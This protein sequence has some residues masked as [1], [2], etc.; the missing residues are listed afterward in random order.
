MTDPVR[1]R[2]L[3]ELDQVTLCTRILYQ[4][5][6]ELYV[7]MK[8][9]DVSLSSLGF[10]AD[11]GRD[12]LGTD[13]HLIYYGPDY[14]L[15]LYKRG[16]TLVNRGY[17][18]MLFH[19]L[20]CHMYTRR[21]RDKGYWDLSCDI[22]MEYVIDGLYQKCVHVPRS[23]LRREMYLRLEKALAEKSRAGKKGGGGRAV[24][25]VLT[26]ERVYR[27]LLE[28]ELPERRL[29]MLRAEFFVDS[30]DLW[31]QESR[32]KIARS[33][34]NQWNDN[35]DRMQTELETGSK[36]ASEDN[37][38]LLEEVR[39]ETGE[40]YDYS[41]FLRKFAVLKEE[42]QVDPDSFDYAFYTYGLSLYGNMPLI[43]PLESREIYRVED[44]AIVIDTSMSCS[45]ELVKRFLEET[46]DVLSETESYFKKVHIHIIQCDDAVQSDV[47]V[48]SQD[49]L[50]AYM[51][52]F[53]IAGSGGTDFR[54]AFEYVNGLKKSRQAA[55]LKGLI[56]FT[57]GKG[58]YP[59]QAPAYDA[60]FVF[61][62]NMFSDESVPP[63]AMKV[64]LEEEQL[65]EYRPGKQNRDAF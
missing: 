12:G 48:T 24:T 32:P 57:D 55:S 53:A 10:E 52:D 20:F 11:W 44:F 30:H 47:L 31:E 37:R 43:E 62:E 42:M 39:V 59:V 38:S 17:L 28:M 58:I 56:Y 46:Y 5:R 40:R 6:S 8:F 60:A 7:N 65:M 15:G 50:K 54:P 19:C 21:D 16:R 23:A 18:H 1:K 35:R 49:E 13:G 9:L 22:A 36:D 4:A 25:P 27:V 26:A 64:V 2:Q 34:Q 61:I 29:D 45:G 14:L 41:R 51:D 3:E 63:W 33:R